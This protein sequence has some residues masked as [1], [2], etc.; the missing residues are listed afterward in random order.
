MYLN[1]LMFYQYYP[2]IKIMHIPYIFFLLNMVSQQ[3]FFSGVRRIPRTCELR[4][5][6]ECVWILLEGAARRIVVV[7]DE[8]LVQ[9]GYCLRLKFG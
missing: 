3:F 7:L 2:Q 4:T 8:G 5:P 1:S 9:L 6:L